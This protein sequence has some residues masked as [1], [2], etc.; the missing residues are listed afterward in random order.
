MIF[1]FFFL[2]HL[3]CV[4]WSA[5]D[6]ALVKGHQTCV[7]LLDNQLR[8]QQ[9]DEDLL[10]DS[11]DSSSGMPFKVKRQNSKESGSGTQAIVGGST[12][13]RRASISRTHLPVPTQQ[14]MYPTENNAGW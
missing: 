7:R 10:K 14:T 6:H 4:G 12:A 9:Q 3:I 5:S 11:T 2:F 1:Q 8:Q 13:Y